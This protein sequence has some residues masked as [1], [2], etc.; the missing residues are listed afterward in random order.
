M[1]R[2]EYNRQETI[3]HIKS[4]FLLRYESYGIDKININELCNQCNVAKS[5]FYQYF[6]DKY[7][8]LEEIETELMDGM[9]KIVFASED[10]PDVSM[11]L[12][13]EPAPIALEVIHYLKS[14]QK[15]FKALLGS[16][17]DPS[18]IKK[19]HRYI[20]KSYEELFRQKKTDSKQGNIAASLFA[21]SLI[22]LYRLYLSENSRISEKD[23]A[24]MAGNLLKCFL[25][26][27][28]IPVKK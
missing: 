26:D 14:N 6:D 2:R 20:I 9:I 8:V 25:Y 23:C 11:I 27:F 1:N 28:E 19:W 24:V 22:E 17:G 4:N 10:K 21:S 3:R 16:N 15:I 5:T 18:F 12:K 13:G 7:S